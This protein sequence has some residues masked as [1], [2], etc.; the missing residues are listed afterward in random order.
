MTEQGEGL[1]GSA[2]V[3]PKSD[4]YLHNQGLG[5]ITVDKTKINKNFLYFLLNASHVRQ[6][7]RNSSSGTKVRHTSPERIYKVK[8]GLPKIKTQK[9]IN[10]FTIL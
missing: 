8:I 2:A 5:L 3:I 1:L 9:K 4:A 6:Q 10:K 7:I